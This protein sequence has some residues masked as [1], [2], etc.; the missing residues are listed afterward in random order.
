MCVPALE[1]LKT[2]E[3]GHPAYQ[4]PQRLKQGTY[5]LQI[6]RFSLLVIYTALKALA[7]G[8]KRLWERF[9]NGDNL[10]FSQ[11]DFEAP[12]QVVFQELRKVPDAEVQKLVQV[13]AQAAQGPMERVPHL[14]E[15]VPQEGAAPS[16]A[17]PLAS[18]KTRA[19][20]AAAVFA[21]IGGQ[22]R[23]SKRRGI[24]QGKKWGIALAG[25]LVPV[26]LLGGIGLLLGVGGSKEPT[27][28]MAE[29]KKIPTLRDVTKARATSPVTSAKA[30]EPKVEPK[31]APTPQPKLAPKLTPPTE[32][33][34]DPKTEPDPGPQNL[35]QLVAANKWANVTVE[36]SFFSPL[37]EGTNWSIGVGGVTW[38]SIPDWLQGTR[39]SA[40]KPNTGATTVKV[41]S[42]GL[43]LIAVSTNWRAG[44]NRS[45]GWYEESKDKEGLLK[46]GWQED[47]IL[48]IQGPLPMQLFW[49]LARKGETYRVRTHKYVPPVVIIGGTVPE[50][51]K[52][53]TS[54][55][56]FERLPG[57]DYV[58]NSLGM[59][60][61][62]IPAGMFTMGSPPAEQNRDADESPHHVEISRPFFMGVYEVTQEEYEKVMGA[63]PS[64]FKNVPG[65]DTRSF[66]VE[67]VSWDNAV[68]FCRKLSE[69]LEERQAG[70]TYRL[71]TEA[72]WEYSCRAGTSTPFH[73]GASLSSEQA[74]FNGGSPYGGAAKG[75][76]L[77]QT[78]TV[79]SYQPNA[80][81]LFDMHGNVWEWCADW[82]DDKY[83]QQSL[84]QN[85]QGPQTGTARVLRGGSW[86]DYGW[87][88][89]AASRELD[90]PEGRRNYLGFRVVCEIAR[91]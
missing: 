24:N 61:V 86:Q 40:P 78:T 22:E 54:G 29:V 49:R 80:F 7:V 31:V 34:P 52:A 63:N 59:K 50:P 83:Y 16:T 70:R 48:P 57:K 44:G 72:E 14:S 10:L 8:G 53:A 19:T 73:Y 89:R 82:Y 76:F 85:P 41:E 17:P 38:G 28:A 21:G 91:P 3:V 30:P 62:L 20:A 46:D 67:T 36:N 51:S 9:D 15:L 56:K 45:G 26:C 65:Q 25:V 84:R 81:G 23:P 27:S 32:L 75:R 35:K 12:G 11:K 77:R 90:G 6:D 58:E 71:P 43:L 68:E 5:G 87:N 42:D 88:C 2:I 66:P 64:H 1:M 37:K 55:P 4:H 60:L 18:T 47:A 13:L 69:R 74:N 39:F 79:G 33:K